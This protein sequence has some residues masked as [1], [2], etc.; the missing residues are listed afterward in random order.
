MTGEGDMKGV[1]AIAQILKQEGVEYLFSYPANS[2]IDAAAAVGIRPI[3]ART[4]KTLINM[5]DGYCRA[6]NG[7]RPAVITVQAGP[8]IENAF[9]GVAQAFA[10]SIPVL[11]LPGGEDQRRSDTPTTFDPLP[12]Y[13]HVTKWAARAN[14]PDRIPELLRRAFTQLRTGQTGPVLLEIPRDVG[15]ADV[16]Q[17]EYRPARGYRAAGDPDDVAEAARLLLGARQPLIHAGHGV[18]WAEAWDELRELAELVR[19]PVMT[20][21]AAKSAFPEDHP[22]SA[23]T[24]G[25]TITGTAAHFLKASDLVLGIGASF[26]AGSFS[27]PIPAGKTLVQVT[28]DERDIDKG[29]RIDLAVLGDAKLVLRQLIGEVRR[30][31]GTAVRGI[32]EDVA[33]TIR[34]TKEAYLQEWMPRLTSDEMPI[35]PYRVVWDLMHTVD[36]RQT[37]VT[38]DSGNP[39]DQMLTFYEALVPRGYLGWGKST[40]LGTGLGLALGAKLA[41]PDKLVVNVMGDLAFGTAGMDVETAVRERIPIMTVILNNSRLGGY[42]HHMP[43]ASDRYGAN[44]LSGNYA[45]VAEGLG[46]YAERVEQ[47]GGVVAALRRGIEATRSG[48]PAV[49]EMITKE[50]PVYPRAQMLLA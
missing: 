15:S 37:I 50:E 36:R 8:G 23:G 32:G 35:N 33:Q 29:Y 5:A 14:F 34:T 7:R 45:R 13:R 48:R 11:L 40:Q 4:E 44:R 17:I 2:L 3:L 1:E 10:D 21:M 28:N 24:G 31:A 9:G 26:S 18:L 39:R 19:V 42:G 25:H 30:Q 27:T 41:H 46:A 47:P 38:H 12:P 16:G 49:L 22:L 20:T 43:V 6:T